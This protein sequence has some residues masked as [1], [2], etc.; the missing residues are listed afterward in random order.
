MDLFFGIFIWQLDNRGKLRL[1]DKV[2][3]KIRLGGQEWTLL[4]L[5]IKKYYVLGP[6][7]KKFEVIRS[8][9]DLNV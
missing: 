6:T 1:V 7:S 3:V 4:I 2:F 5:F 9:W 8:P